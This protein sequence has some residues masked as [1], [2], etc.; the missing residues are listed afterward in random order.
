MKPKLSD[1]SVVEK[2]S[3]LTD[4]T[5]KD[6]CQAAYDYLMLSEQSSYSHFVELRESLL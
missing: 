6:R 4:A 2:I 1:K 5:A 3:I